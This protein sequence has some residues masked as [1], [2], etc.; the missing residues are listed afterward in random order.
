M[1]IEAGNYPVAV[2]GAGTM[3]RGIAQVAASAGHPVMLYD[4]SEKQTRDAI[5]FI[6]K[7][8][9]DSFKKGKIT[10]NSKVQV[11]KN[12]KPVHVLDELF[13]AK[14]IIEAVIEDLEIKQELFCR[15]ES[16]LEAE[17]I[18]STNTSS[19]DLNKIVTNLKH[20]ERFVGMHFFNPVPVMALVEIIH[21]AETD[22]MITEF[23]SQLVKK[24]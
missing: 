23:V 2:M 1:K 8:L 6:G 21:T 11:L 22:P 12:I 20:P 15:L 10:E 18:L 4:V 16:F 7:R 5:E 14:L 13:E 3:G 19:L 24:W 17:S 9:E